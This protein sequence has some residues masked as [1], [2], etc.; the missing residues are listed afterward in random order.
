MNIHLDLAIGKWRYLSEK[1][2]H[3]IN[4]LVESSS[5]LSIIKSFANHSEP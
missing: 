1:E 5:K 4:S 2:L 3:E